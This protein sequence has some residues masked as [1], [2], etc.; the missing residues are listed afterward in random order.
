MNELRYPA[1][2]TVLAA[3]T[4]SAFRSLDTPDVVLCVAEE[5][6]TKRRN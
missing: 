5:S 6:E 3:V 4:V 2:V 1:S